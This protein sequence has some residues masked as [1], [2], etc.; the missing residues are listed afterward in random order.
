MT[1]GCTA[2]GCER[3][4]V[5]AWTDPQFFMDLD[6]NN[7]PIKDEKGEF[8]KWG[9]MEQGRGILDDISLLKTFF[10]ERGKDT[11]TPVWDR[12]ALKGA[13]E[14]DTI[15]K[16]FFNECIA[17]CHD[18]GVQCLVGFEAIGDRAAP[19]REWFL[20]HPMKPPIHHFADAL[21]AKVERELPQCDGISFD[22]EHLVYSK[23]DLQRVRGPLSTFYQAVADK[24]DKTSKVVGV[25]VA[26]L[27]SDLHRHYLYAGDKRGRGEPAGAAARVHDYRLAIGHSNILIR[28]MGYLNFFTSKGHYN[29]HSWVKHWHEDIV[30]YAVDPQLQVKLPSS[31]FQLGL[32][33]RRSEPYGAFITNPRV[34]DER[35]KEVLRPR[36]VGLIFFP[37]SAG[38]WEH[39]DQALNKDYDAPGAFKLCEPC[40][41]PLDFRSMRRAFQPRTL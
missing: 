29:N 5:S 35:C 39:C 23:A 28:P 7:V 34:M 31:Q 1:N 6:S 30:D 2:A 17:E 38:H 41:A 20:G 9:V 27:V 15:R 25:A 36:K 4:R 18:Y 19:M 33:T 37:T 12:T 8:F 10:Y 13:K 40:Q 22:I 24:M 11:M 16:K 21:V 14:D 26:G 32:H 3:M